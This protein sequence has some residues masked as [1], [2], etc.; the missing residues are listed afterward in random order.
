[1]KSLLFQEP[2]PPYTPPEACNFGRNEQEYRVI[3]DGLVHIM[4]VRDK[5]V[6]ED[7]VLSMVKATAYVLRTGEGYPGVRPSRVEKDKLIKRTVTI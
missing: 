5:L 6:A 1:M 4:R 7:M 2:T 3:K